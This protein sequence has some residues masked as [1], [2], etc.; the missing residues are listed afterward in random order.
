M[1][2]FGRP[3]A[4]SPGAAMQ[5]GFY[6]NPAN[7]G[8]SPA[9]II[10]TMPT[11]GSWDD[12]LKHESITGLGTD[13]ARTNY[14][15]DA[16]GLSGEWKVDNGRLTHSAPWAAR[17]A[18]ALA[19]G[20]MV[21]GPALFS[22]FGGGGAGAAGAASSIGTGA[23]YAAPTSAAAALGGA[24]VAGATGGGMTLG[25]LINSPLFGKGVEGAFGLYGSHKAGKSADRA[26]AYQAA[27]DERMFA[28]EVQR[29]AEARRQWEAQQAMEK[30]RL[31]AEEEERSYRR[32]LDE[33][34]EA[35]RAPYRQA[36]QQA[37]G[38]LLGMLRGGNGGW[39]SPSQVGRT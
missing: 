32:T 6:A 10:A 36:S 30:Q 13:T 29:D 34:R 8:K 26:A 11:F 37:L 5:T 33:Q 38:Q 1:P 19:I 28:L 9:S 17:W 2:D 12:A 14:L 7:R 20:A 35:R 31:D 15:R 22:A 18:P 23:T 27:A 24:S 16:Y 3:T 25:S 21:G 39:L 4:P